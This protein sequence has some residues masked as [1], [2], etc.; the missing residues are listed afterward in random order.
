[1]MNECCRSQA[2]A[3]RF[4]HAGVQAEE[5]DCAELKGSGLELPPVGG[6][7]KSTFIH[8]LYCTRPISRQIGT[9]RSSLVE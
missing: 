3:L 1:M 9:V 6:C 5:G 7:S 8:L 4:A 2:R